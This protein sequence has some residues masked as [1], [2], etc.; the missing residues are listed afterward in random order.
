M[1]SFKISAAF[2]FVKQNSEPQY[3]C[4]RNLKR[5][6]AYLVDAQIGGIKIS[7]CTAEVEGRVI[8][9]GSVQRFNVYSSTEQ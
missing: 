1:T 8:G 2:V 3:V 6:H 5:V 4:T 9:E 7:V